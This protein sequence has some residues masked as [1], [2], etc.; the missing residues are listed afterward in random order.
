MICSLR[1]VN[2]PWDRR[3]EDA[4]GLITGKR[5]AGGTWLAAGRYG[6]RVFFN[7]EQAGEPGRWN[8]LRGLRIMQWMQKKAGEQRS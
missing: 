8:T 3:M 1:E 6:G 7:M 5:K 2:T 4:A